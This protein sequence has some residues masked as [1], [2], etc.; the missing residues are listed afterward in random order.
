MALL[1]L[2]F[3]PSIRAERIADIA[4]FPD[5]TTIQAIPEIAAL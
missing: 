4:R 5:W 2:I 3:T 1:D